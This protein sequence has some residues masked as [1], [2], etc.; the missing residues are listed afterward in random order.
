MSGGSW[1]ILGEGRADQVFLRALLNALGRTDLDIEV[2]TIGG[3]YT[4]L[5]TNAVKNQILRAADSGKGVALVLDANSSIEETRGRYHK[6]VEEEA[7]P[8]DRVF[9]LPNDADSGD[10]ESLLERL[11]V[12]RHRRVLDCFER[13]EECLRA[14]DAGYHTPNRKAKIYAY[15][16][17]IGGEP[18]EGERRYLD[19]SQW[20]LDAVGLEPLKE[21]PRTM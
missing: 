1:L 9:F 5:K 12:D 13:Y 2:D 15:C 10:L 7:L 4:K 21:F 20:N 11:A 17:A 6:A 3:D 19:R 8:I 14:A 18:K 16:E